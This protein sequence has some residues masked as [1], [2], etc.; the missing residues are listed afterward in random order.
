M[1]RICKFSLVV[2]FAAFLIV[3][4]INLVIAWMFVSGMT[5]P[6]CRSSTP[7]AG[8]PQPEEYWIETDDDVS[9]RIWYYPSQNGGAVLS[10]GGLTGS[11]G[12]RIP[13]VIPLI[14]A[15]YGVV[16]IDSRAC[17]EPS[18]PVT[19]GGN[20]VLDAEAALEF[21]LS[22]P[23]VDPDRIGA[24]G[25]SMGGATAIRVAARQPQIR[26]VVRDGGFTNLGEL[27]N[28]P[29][30]AFIANLYRSTVETVFRIQTGV[31]PWEVSPIDDLPTISPGAVF[32]IYGEHESG[33]G[34]EQYEV[35]LEP[36]ELWIVPNGRH[37][38]NHIAAPDL[39]EQKV[40]DFFRISLGD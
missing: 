36:K 24:I 23:D 39:Y 33:A 26:G 27:L 20:E 10:F 34:Y 8:Y 3:F 4:G 13:P 5:H 40:L 19:L 16:Q 30:S 35:A 29:E 15:G 12:N 2:G 18:A 22:R 7:I 17:A 6:G 9:L 37:G 28:P 14:E 32:F 31:D 1:K 25:F 38:T 21:L 11:L